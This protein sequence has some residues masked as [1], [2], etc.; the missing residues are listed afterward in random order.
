VAPIQTHEA[1]IGL[2]F[3][4][5]NNLLIDAKNTLIPRSGIASIPRLEVAAISTPPIPV[6]GYDTQ[7]KW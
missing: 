5:N 1:I 4:V 2:P 7:G 6:G 3:L